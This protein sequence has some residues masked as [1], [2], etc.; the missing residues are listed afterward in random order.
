[1]GEY[2]DLGKRGEE[3]AAEYLAGKGYI[4]MEMNWRYGREEIDI[5]ARDKNMVVFAEVKTRSGS[6]IRAPEYAVNRRKQQFLIHAANAYLQAKRIDL[7]ARFDIVCVII[8][9]HTSEVG[10]IEEAFNPVC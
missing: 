7:E 10:H 1:M 6:F 9:G 4:I 3:L 8:R 2:N 5:I